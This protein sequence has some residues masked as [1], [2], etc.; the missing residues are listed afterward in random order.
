MRGRATDS[1][2][3][4]FGV[5]A[6][7][8]GHFRHQQRSKR[9][10]AARVRGRRAPISR[11][12]AEVGAGSSTGV[13]ASPH[14]ANYVAGGVATATYDKY[15]H[16]TGV[17]GIIAAQSGNGVGIASIPWRDRRRATQAPPR[18]RRPRGP[19]AALAGVIRATR[20]SVY[21]PISSGDAGRSAAPSGDRR[22]IDAQC[23]EDSAARFFNN[24]SELTCRRRSRLRRRT[25]RRSGG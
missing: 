12:R 15:K 17:A 5:R 23:I 21:S 1:C 20:F 2:G 25:T 6:R 11:R 8:S 3:R 14:G 7:A 18:R 16:G 9:R 10:R 22:R 13:D 24:A 19:P 4:R